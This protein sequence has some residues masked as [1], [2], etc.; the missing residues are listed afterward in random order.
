MVSGRSK[1]AS[2]VT[3]PFTKISHAMATMKVSSS[4]NPLVRRLGRARTMHLC[5][6]PWGGPIPQSWL[7]A[8]RALPRASPSTLATC[9]TMHRRQG[10]GHGVIICAGQGRVLI[11]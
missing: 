1:V 11:S 5:Q 4:M 3:S 2:R 7:A 9:I 10:S 6:E 8:P